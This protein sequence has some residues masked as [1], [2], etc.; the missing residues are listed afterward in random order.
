MDNQDVRP[1]DSRNALNRGRLSQRG[2]DERRTHESGN[3]GAS[4]SENASGK[5]VLAFG[6]F[7][8]FH[9]GHRFYL[10]EAAKEGDLTVV[11]GR[12][13]TVLKVKGRRPLRPE[14]ERLAEVLAKG[15][16]AV[17]GSS[18]DK[19]AV[20]S[21]VRPDVIALG[22]DQQAF[23]GRLAE[24][25]AARGLIKAKIVRIAAHRPDTYKSSLLDAHARTDR[26][27]Q[28]RESG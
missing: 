13:E 21:E 25:C 12:D 17:L 27:D 2:E 1:D 18:G 5:R 24:E 11:V 16:H 15:Y 26:L 20:L 28:S 22:Y 14:G 4:T 3:R 23:T 6:T 9:D 7:D 8:G 19:Y 10:D